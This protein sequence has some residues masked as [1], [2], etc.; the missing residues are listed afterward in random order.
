MLKAGRRGVAAIMIL[1]AFLPPGIASAA[2]FYIQEQTAAGVGRG[3]AGNG[4]AADDAS[5]AY[6]N[7]AGMTE[8][9][10]VQFDSGIDLIV[11][12]ASL[13]DLGSA[14]HTPYVP[15]APLGGNSGGNPGS[16]T[17]IPNMYMTAEIPNSPVTVGLAVTAPFGFATK[18]AQGTFTRYDSIDTFLET[19]DIAPTIAVKLTDWLSVGVGLD[20]QYVYIKLRNALPDPFGAPSPATDGRLTLTGH[21][22]STGF[23]AGVLLMPGPDTKIGF[24]YRY[25]ITHNING[26]VTLS[27][28]SG[29]LAA[30]D[31]NEAGAAALNLPDIITAGV[32]RQVM[33]DLKLLGEF[34][35]FTW[36]NFKA[37]NI[38]LANNGGSL[39][40]PENYRDTVSVALGAEYQLN[41]RW[42][43]RAGIKYDQTPT[44][45]AYRDTRV[46]DGDRYW[47]STGFHYAFDEH[48]GIDGSYAHIFLADSPV[49]VSRGFY[50][51][52]GLTTTS[53]IDA[54]SHV[55]FDILTLGLSYKF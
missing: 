10:G 16:A 1:S 30:G 4:V 38:V 20:E 47:L 34:D 2:G 15:A 35:Y 45:N 5:T 26:S 27:G 50:Q 42:R 8:L 36:S 31:T 49:N 43:L 44:V 18:Y 6:F 37:I 23:N 32:S 41:E 46:P 54:E 12:S 40:T 53:V 11:P 21:T 9:P 51:Q 13:S 14:D 22:W 3:Q 39:D 55:A 33:P 7:P 19:I 48:I 29:P 17:P 25:G 28:L 24:T 52:Y